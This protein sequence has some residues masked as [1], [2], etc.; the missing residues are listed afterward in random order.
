ME[1]PKF[2]QRQLKRQS[3]RQGVT[4]SLGVVVGNS[5]QVYLSAGSWKHKCK[6]TA[7][8][9]Q[10]FEQLVKAAFAEARRPDLKRKPR[11]VRR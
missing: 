4:M 7:E 6:T 10:V 8:S 5:G 1:L 2:E 11:E 3:E 9:V